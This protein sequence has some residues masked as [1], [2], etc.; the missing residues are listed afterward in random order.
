LGSDR[1]HDATLALGEVLPASLIPDAAFPVAAGAKPVRVDA[2]G[3]AAV[4]ASLSAAPWVLVCLVPEGALFLRAAPWFGI[5]LGLVALLAVVLSVAHLYLQRRFVSPALNLVRLIGA[6]AG[7]DVLPPQRVPVSWQPW[8]SRVSTAFATTR[9]RLARASADVEQLVR[10]A[11]ERGREASRFEAALLRES[12][13]HGFVGAVVDA[14]PALLLVLDRN[15]RIVRF[16]RRCEELS[17]VAASAARGRKP[18]SFLVSADENELVRVQVETVLR[19]DGPLAETTSHWLC[20]GGP[21]RRI[22]WW[23]AALTDDHGEITHVVAL[24]LAAA[25]Q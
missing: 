13:D 20:P 10:L 15:G 12:A 14:V 4:V 11:D 9:A 22:T 18:W 24:G 8:F 19:G 25:Q 23:L 3:Y 1:G 16:N 6:E 5:T 2:Q 21:P 7:G 17:G